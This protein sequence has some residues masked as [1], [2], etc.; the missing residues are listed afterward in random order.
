MPASMQVQS[1]LFFFNVSRAGWTSLLLL[2]S[3]SPAREAT[4]HEPRL[5]RPAV[6]GTTATGF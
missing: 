3:G 6:P 1:I 4:V 2:L 5:Q